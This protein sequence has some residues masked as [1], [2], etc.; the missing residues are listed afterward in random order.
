MMRTFDS[1]TDTSERKDARSNHY[2]YSV[3]DLS[4]GKINSK[5][6]ETRGNRLDNFRINHNFW[7][8][9]IKFA[10]LIIFIVVPFRKLVAQPFMV[11]GSSMV[12]TFENSDYLIVNQLT[13]HFGKY[14]RFDV[15]VFKYPEDPS[16]FYIKRLIGLP[17]ERIIVDDSQVLLY[18]DIYP[19]GI[20]INSDYA[21]GL[22]IGRTD[23]TLGPKEYFVL[24]DN[25]ENSSD[26]RMWG[27][28][29]L[30]N[31]VGVPVLRILPLNHA[32]FGPGQVDP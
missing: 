22:T 19:D 2:L 27:A 20:S 8:E 14:D 9:I 3:E 15:V 23:I 28:L 29:P 21:T 31:I 26:S 17:G 12:P 24:G 32:G 13:K 10:L 7:Y 11:S 16:K 30:D 4:G 5:A 1:L 25:R 18:N 6:S